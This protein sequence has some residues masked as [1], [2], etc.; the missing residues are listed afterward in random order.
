MQEAQLDAIAM[1]AAEA[2]KEW[3]DVARLLDEAKAKLDRTAK[4]KSDSE[5][6]KR[7]REILTTTNTN[8]HI[9]PANVQIKNLLLEHAKTTAARKDAEEQLQT[10]ETTFEYSAKSTRDLFDRMVAILRKAEEASD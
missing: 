5:I 3:L 2:H 7:I 6:N 10:I 4:P 9:P 1:K 8:P